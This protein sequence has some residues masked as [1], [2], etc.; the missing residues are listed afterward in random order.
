MIDPSIPLGVRPLELPNVGQTLMGMAQMK[1]QRAM[2]QQE[3]Q[4]RTQEMQQ[5]GLQMQQAQ[6]GIQ[7]GMAAEKQMQVID[8]LM[9]SSMKPDADTGVYSFDRGTFEQGLVQQG[10]GHLYPQMSETLDK[11]DQSAA[12]MATERRQLL[13]RSIFAVNQ[14]GNT[15]ES[16]LTA[17]A[18]LKK[19][20]A[21]TDEHVQPIMQAIQQDASPQSIGALMTKMGAGLPEYRDLMNAEEKRKSDLAHV[22]AQTA[23]EQAQAAG[24]TADLPKKTADALMATRVAANMSPEGLTPAQQT[25]ARNE[26]QRITLEQQRVGLERQRLAQSAGDRTE[27][28]SAGLD[29]AA[30]MFVKT[31]QL[32]ALGMGDKTTRKDIINRAAV[33][34]PGL[35]VASAKADF[36]ANTASLQALQKSRDAIGAFEQ[37]AVKNIDLFLQT[38]GKVVDTGSPL[39]NS[40]ARVVSGKMLGS[41]DQAAYEAARQVAIN[42]VAKITS[43]PTLSG[44]LSDSAR[45]EVESFNPQNAT[46]RQTVA[47]MRTLKQDMGNRASSMDDQIAAIQTRIAKASQPATTAAPAPVRQAAPAARGPAE[48]DTKPLDASG[49]EA[50][51][52]NG[53]WIRTK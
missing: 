49:A 38:A 1:Q 43:N 9:A 32:P 45:K 30:L 53:K 48:G 7:K 27:L 37:T 4:M 23:H 50:T 52:R 24:L 12:K 46:L 17:I 20:G 51:Y 28:T 15:P 42:E 31:G 19:N 6:I 11:L 10:Q 29:A 22:G 33:M 26:G 13:A 47:V 5:R 21:V 41:P 14:A 34:V 40:I 2:Q 44:Q 36:G 3:M 25:T 8:Q 39:A 16:V 18:Y 35:D